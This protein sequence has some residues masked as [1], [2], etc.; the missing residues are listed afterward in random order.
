M[1]ATTADSGHLTSECK[2]IPHRLVIR[3]VKTAGRVVPTH[4]GGGVAWSDLRESNP[5]LPAWKAVTR[6]RVDR[7]TVFRLGT[8]ETTFSG[9]VTP[10][11]PPPRYLTSLHSNVA[12]IPM[13]KYLGWRLPCVVTAVQWSKRHAEYSPPIFSVLGVSTI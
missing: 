5:S 12:A 11:E 6:R 2:K 1:T 3:G 8:A 4:S 13:R 9:T 7:K 10:L